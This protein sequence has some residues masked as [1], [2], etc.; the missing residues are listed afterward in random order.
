MSSVSE[1]A[2]QATTSQD[3]TAERTLRELFFHSSFEP[4][5]RPSTSSSYRAL[6]EST[7][8]P[9]VSNPSVADW[10]AWCE[11]FKGNAEAEL[12]RKRGTTL[13]DPAADQAMHGSRSPM[14]AAGRST[15]PGNENVPAFFQDFPATGE[16]QMQ[17]YTFCR[18]P[19]GQSVKPED[20]NQWVSFEVHGDICKAYSDNTF[21][22]GRQGTNSR[23]GYPNSGLE[24]AVKTRPPFLDDP[25]VKAFR[26]A[27]VAS[28][29]P[30]AVPF[31]EF[32][33]GYLADLGG[34][35]QAFSKD[36]QRLG[37]TWPGGDMTAAPTQDP[38][39]VQQPTGPYGTTGSLNGD[40]SFGNATVQMGTSASHGGA[41]TSLVYDGKEYI[42]NKDHGRQMQVAFSLDGYNEAL[43][44]TEA[45][46]HRN[47][48][49]PIST[50]QVVGYGA[51]L[52]HMTSTVHPAYWLE[53]GEEAGPYNGV[54]HAKNTTLVSEDLITKDITVGVGGHD[55]V[56]QY[57]SHIHLAAPHD[58]AYVEA[59]TTYVNREFEKHYRFDPATGESRE[60]PRVHSEDPTPG[61]FKDEAGNVPL[62]VATEDGKHAMAI[63]SPDEALPD[64]QYRL[65]QFDLN[66]PTDDCSKLSVTFGMSGGVPEDIK[67]RSYVIVGTVEEV[68]ARLAE[69][70]N[71]NPTGV[72]RKWPE[73]MR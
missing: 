63:W 27:R 24:D 40:T 23:L 38:G 33:N 73:D 60:Y 36:G 44:P 65:H 48:T 58:T 14:Y 64:L 53:P 71:Q 29:K 50:T 2:S 39:G 57:D 52:G 54:S 22:H 7:P 34:K 4:R 35:V 42:N 3:S 61:G 20:R 45:G 59:P 12:T 67:T 11:Q 15:V 62:I 47:G 32:Q 70:Y 8:P 26:D 1:P 6:A 41:V 9:D 31:Q 16:R 19:P 13:P 25:M 69:L 30:D 72:E 5:S 66:N 21:T 49:E 37:T 55:N 68:K 18:P 43:M 56:I 51:Q 28:G 46:S 17:L 10:Q